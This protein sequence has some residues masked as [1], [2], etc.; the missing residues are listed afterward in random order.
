M[1]RFG[2]YEALLLLGAQHND[3]IVNDC[4]MMKYNK[5]NNNNLFI[6]AAALLL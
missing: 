1:Y 4:Y 2:F 3:N 6:S 5:K